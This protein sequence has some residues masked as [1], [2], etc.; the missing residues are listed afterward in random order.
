MKINFYNFK[1]LGYINQRRL[2]K[3][4]L[5]WLSDQLEVIPKT[6]Q[7][8]VLR[9]LKKFTVNI[10][11]T[12]SKNIMY[13]DKFRSENT[14]NLSDKIPWEVMGM[15][16]LQLFIIDDKKE[17]NFLSGI[18]TMT[19]GL[20]HVL[21]WCFD[22]KRRVELRY[23]D[24]SG[25]KKGDVLSWHV[26]AVHSRTEAIEKTVQKTKDVELD[27]EIY[28]LDTYREIQP[29]FW[30]KVQYRVWDFRDDLR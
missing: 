29:K 4:A 21:L 13:P 30:K 26:A 6:D 25:N 8:R 1:N 5:K 7:Q 14:G 12:T 18:M 24:A 17:I 20:G 23:D 10:M 22:S 2:R 28:Y 19:H 15:Y 11:P 3:I 16:E 27:N 9:E